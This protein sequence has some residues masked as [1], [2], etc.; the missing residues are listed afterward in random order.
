MKDEDI[1]AMLTGGGVALG[2]WFIVGDHT[3]AHPSDCGIYGALLI[4]DDAA[5]ESCLDFLRRRGAREFASLAEVIQ[6]GLANSEW[7]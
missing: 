7:L 6:A 5:A 3:I 2:D 1:I 4:E